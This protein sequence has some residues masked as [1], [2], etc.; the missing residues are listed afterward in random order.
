M[1]LADNLAEG[2]RSQLASECSEQSAETRESIICWLLGDVERFEQQAMAYRYRILQQRYLGVGPERAYRHLLRRLGSLVLLRNKIRTWVASSRDRQRAVVDVLE[3]V[4]QEL[5]TSDRYL[6][7]QMAWI[8][9]CSA[10]AKLRNALLFASTEEY[11]LRPIRNQPL[12]VYRFINYHYRNQR[13]GLTQVPTSESIWLIS[14][15]VLTQDNEN[16]ITLLDTKAVVQYQDTQAAENQQLAR[17]AVKQ[18]F[19][20]DLEKKLGLVAVQWLQLHLQGRSQEEIASCLNLPVKQVYRL[21]EK[22]S[23]HALH[24]F[25]LKI[26]P[27]L[28]GNWLENSLTEHSFGLTPLQWQQFGLRLTPRQQHLCELLKAGK[29][30]EAIALDLKLKTHQVMGEWSKIYLAAQALR[31]NS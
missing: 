20:L 17:T 11:C 7:Q 25:A 30:L 8:A 14:E 22:I 2:W 15:Q 4:I 16:P 10:D 23:Y 29:N 27:E 3:E 21:R 26:E 31:S 28:V 9:E 12:L 13:G 19:E 24:V 6:Q 5:L 18:K 1:A